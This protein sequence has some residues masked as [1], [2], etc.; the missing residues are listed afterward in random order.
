MAKGRRGANG[1]LELESSTPLLGVRGARGERLK[2]KAFSWTSTSID[3]MIS[4]EN[5]KGAASAGDR[6]PKD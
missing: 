5:S 3:L 1:A 2:G 4:G 6:Y